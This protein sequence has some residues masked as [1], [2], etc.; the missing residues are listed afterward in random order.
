M[1]SKWGWW[2]MWI[3]N[4]DFSLQGSGPLSLRGTEASF[5][6][7]DFSLQGSGPLTLRGTSFL[8]V[9]WKQQKTPRALCPLAHPLCFG[10]LRNLQASLPYPWLLI[11]F[12]FC[13]CNSGG[14][15]EMNPTAVGKESPEWLRLWRAWLHSHQS[16]LFTGWMVPEAWEFVF[17]TIKGKTFKD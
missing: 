17:P 3:V 2:G 7:R 4:R 9:S 6:H 10:H 14:T 8:P 5:L 16:S 15:N 11:D 1:S 13:E 12:S